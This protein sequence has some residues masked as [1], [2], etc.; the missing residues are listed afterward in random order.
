LASFAGILDAAFGA[1]DFGLIGLAIVKAV[2]FTSI[3]LIYEG[4]DKGS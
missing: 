2:I 3:F 1:E 4:V